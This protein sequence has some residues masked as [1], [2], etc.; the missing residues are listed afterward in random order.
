MHKERHEWH[1]AALGRPMQLLWYGHWGQ[2]VLAF[3]TSLGHANQNEDFGLIGGLR[4]KID[5]GL[6]QVCCVDAVDE[7]AW[8][9]R[10]AHPADRAR[11]QD[12]YDR[13]L[14]SEAAPFIRGKAERPDIISYGASFGGYH[15]ANFGLRHPD[16]V[17]RIVAF[18]GLFDIHRFL[19]AYWDE[20]CYYHCPSAYVANYPPDWVERVD[21]L[22]I[23]V[24]TGEHDHLASETRSFSDLLRRKGIPVQS[25]LWPGVNGHDWGFWIDHLR[26]V[27]P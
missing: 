18:S 7:E 10:G 19:G 8:Y 24:A 6:V 13:Y 11:R 23:V 14:A 1:S 5:G 17:S 15:A 22:G 21:R 26:R 9:N 4:D 27:L 16:L 2:P 3:P 12:A 20:T 25:E